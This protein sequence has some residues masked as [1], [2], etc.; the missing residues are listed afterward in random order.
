MDFGYD[1]E[2]LFWTLF[3]TDFT[4]VFA[5]RLM[6]APSKSSH[7]TKVDSSN[8]FGIRALTSRLLYTLMSNCMGRSATERE[9]RLLTI[10]ENRNLGHAFKRWMRING[11]R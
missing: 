11:S 2:T 3:D 6:S 4:P 9:N 5:V 10:R 1:F 8:V 7:M